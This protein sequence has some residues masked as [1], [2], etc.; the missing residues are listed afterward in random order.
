V[1]DANMQ[2]VWSANLFDILDVT[3][4]ATGGETCINGSIV[5]PGLLLAEIANDW[6]H[7]NAI[8]YSPADGNLIVSLRNQDWVIKIDYRDGAGAGG[9]IW[10]LGEE[11]DFTPL[12]FPG[13]TDPWFTHQHDANYLGS[14]RLINFDNGNRS[15]ACLTDRQDCRSRGQVWTLDES[16]MTAT[17]ETNADLGD[18]SS[19]LGAAEALSNG[20]YSFNSGL[21]GGLVVPLS[22]LDEVR[23]DGTK[24]FSMEFNE[25]AYR[26]FRLRDLYT[27]PSYD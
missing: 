25:R 27:A 11:G 13:D 22:R 3:R 26:G 15:D 23:A 24:V 20:N 2:L 17:L 8:S 9:L 19:G 10:R 14:N 16:N 5:C 1:L 6:T 21:P 18:Y 4:L 12:G 7:S